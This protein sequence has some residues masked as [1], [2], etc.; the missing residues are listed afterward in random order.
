MTAVGLFALP[1]GWMGCS[2]SE[3]PA[4]KASQT[5]SAAFDKSEFTPKEWAKIREMD[6]EDMLEYK[7]KLREAR[8]SAGKPR[9]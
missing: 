6:R 4:P 7:Q 8:K 2:P 5:T 1:M 9:S 3:T